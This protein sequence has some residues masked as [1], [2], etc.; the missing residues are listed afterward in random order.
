M[1]QCECM[2][3]WGVSARGS[4]YERVMETVYLSLCEGEGVSRCVNTC[5]SV[6]WLMF[7]Y[8]CVYGCLR[9]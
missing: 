3:V 8:L 1:S 2:C 5:T 6:L 4:V 9:E 7:V